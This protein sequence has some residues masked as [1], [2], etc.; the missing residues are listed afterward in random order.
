VVVVDLVRNEP[1]VDSIK[2][3]GYVLSLSLLS[4]LRLLVSLLAVNPVPAD[5]L[6]MHPK[7][8]VDFFILISLNMDVCC[9][10]IRC[11]IIWLSIFLV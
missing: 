8:G 6:D 9:L 4:I 5:I 1:P 2:E 11:F 7:L 10:F 3:F